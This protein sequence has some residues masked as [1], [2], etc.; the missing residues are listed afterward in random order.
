M[1]KIFC[2]SPIALGFLKSET[3]DPPLI[4]FLLSLLKEWERF[5]LFNEIFF[6][7]LKAI[8]NA[9]LASGPKKTSADGEKMKH[10]KDLTKLKQLDCVIAISGNTE[11]KKSLVCRRQYFSAKSQLAKI[12]EEISNI[13]KNFDTNKTQNQLFLN[14]CNE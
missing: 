10:A 1:E 4:N 7:K 5:G 3:S 9:K 8:L 11:L 14:A 6:E 2:P 12:F 13:E